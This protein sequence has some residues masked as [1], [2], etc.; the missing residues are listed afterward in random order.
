VVSWQ[1]PELEDLGLAVTSRSV[2]GKTH[3]VGDLISYQNDTKG[4]PMTA[5]KVNS[6]SEYAAACMAMLTD[7]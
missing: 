2:A 3:R 1:R 7:Q 4:C 5:G 6:V